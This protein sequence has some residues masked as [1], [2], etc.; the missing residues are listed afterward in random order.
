V[1]LIV[2][3]IAHIYTCN[4]RRGGYLHPLYHFGISYLGLMG[5][6][7]LPVPGVEGK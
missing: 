4:E 2:D 6:E 5:V 3:D 1:H 7:P